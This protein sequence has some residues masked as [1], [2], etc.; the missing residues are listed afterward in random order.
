[1]EPVDNAR[2]KQ[3]ESEQYQFLL[4]NFKFR[5]RVGFGGKEEK[6]KKN[7]G[8]VRENRRNISFLI[9]ENQS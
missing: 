1:M 4:I 7:V 5:Y 8:N 6:R 9:T 3:I 2:S